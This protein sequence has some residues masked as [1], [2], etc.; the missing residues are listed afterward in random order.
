MNSG[1]DHSPETRSAGA[2]AFFDMLT[3]LRPVRNVWGL[4]D[5]DVHKIDGR[6]VMFL[7]GFTN[8]FKVSLFSATLPLGASLTSDQWSLVTEPNRPSHALTLTPDAD[9]GQWDG[10]GMH[11][12]SWVRGLLPD[13]TENERIYYAGRSS[14]SITGRDSRY[15][16]GYLHRTPSGWLRHG[17]P[18]HTGTSARPSVLEPLVRYDDGLW[19]MWY[20]SAISEVGRGELPDYQLKYVESD[21]G[22]SGWSSPQVLFSTK[23][24]YF[25]CAVQ[26][27]DDHYEMVVARGTNL[28]GTPDFPPQGLWWLRSPR[29][30]GRRADWTREP[31]RLLDAA[32]D[33]QPWFA[34]GVC[35]PSFHYR[36][37]D[38]DREMMHVFCTGT[39]AKTSWLKTTIARLA[40]GRRPPVP[41]PYYLATGQIT[42][43]APTSRTAYN[44]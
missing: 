41:A 16:I 13:G 10:R 24:G 3:G 34:S 25:N 36:E 39:Y 4:S 2:V 26:Q 27:V 6:W 20:L 19:R 21:D 14:R 5:P 18:V 15:A 12:P 11:S 38:A 29:P 8:R 35:S 17:P 7:G 32:V 9:K 22:T 37:T 43:L 44:R 42:V 23:D 40:H 33:P 30:T 28:Y 1:P 31:V